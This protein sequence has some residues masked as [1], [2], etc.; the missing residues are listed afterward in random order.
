MIVPPKVNDSDL[1][2]MPVSEI[3]KVGKISFGVTR[4]DYI[5]VLQMKLADRIKL[6]G[7]VKASL[8]W[9]KIGLI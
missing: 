2:N 7:I 5:Q 4:T 8:L 9:T 6:V 1:D 3:M